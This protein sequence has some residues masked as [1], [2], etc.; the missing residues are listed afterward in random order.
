LES[1]ITAQNTK[2][3]LCK[4]IEQWDRAYDWKTARG[5][6]APKMPEARAS[7]PTHHVLATIDKEMTVNCN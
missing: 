5:L 1:K 7:T 4:E 3:K 6:L 2:G